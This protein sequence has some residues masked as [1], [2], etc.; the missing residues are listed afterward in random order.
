MK[1]RSLL[2]LIVG[3]MLVV[4]ACGGGGTQSATGNSASPT[5]ES[6]PK[7]AEPSYPTKPV[8]FIIQYGAGGGTDLSYRAILKN[9]EKDFGK[10]IV[11]KN[12]EGGGGITGITQLSKADPNGYSA[13]VIAAGQMV[14]APLFKEV[15]VSL[16]DFVVAG[17]FGEFLY[18]IIVKDDAPYNTFEE[19]VQ[20]VKDNPGKLNASTVPATVSTV[21][22]T[23]LKSEFGLEFNELPFNSSADSTKALLDGSADFTFAVSSGTNP[24]IESKDVKLIAST[25][26]SRWPIAPE[27]PTLLELG[28]EN[29][30]IR[31]FLGIGFPKGTPEDVTSKWEDAIKKALEDPEVQDQFKKMSVEPSYMSAEEFKKNLEDLDHNLK[32]MLGKK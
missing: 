26:N 3:M 24:L 2:C 1:Y 21:L 19:F 25:S 8:E 6:Q 23:W 5:S 29:A 17:A 18:G 20:Y 31:T 14:H 7:A 28:Y 27:V 16:D 13:G 12:V 22:Y 32:L 4:T 30:S 11:V 15:P 9:I 10:S